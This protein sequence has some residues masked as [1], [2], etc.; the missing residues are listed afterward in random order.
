[1]N[2]SI[3]FYGKL[4][5]ATFLLSAFTFGGGY[6]IVSLMKK[7]FVDDYDWFKQ[8]EMLDLVAIAQS[9]PGPI[10]INTA[11]I[12]G[13]QLGG[14]WGIFLTVI[15]T[16]LPPFAIISVVAL[17]Y[18]AFIQ[19]QWVAW[20]LEGMQA[21]VAAVIASVIYEMVVNMSKNHGRFR[22]LIYGIALIAILIVKVTTSHII[23]ISLLAGVI[24]SFFIRDKETT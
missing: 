20:A 16:A 12:V 8:E 9:S 6:V 7:Q 11:I 10:A 21:G 17:F 19:N 23:F 22:L 5:W 4:F 18:Q 1:M 24:Y 13:Y 3:K 15:A 14:F 2:K